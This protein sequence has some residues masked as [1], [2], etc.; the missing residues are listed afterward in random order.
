MKKLINYLVDNQ[1]RVLGFAIV[2]ALLISM[3]TSFIVLDESLTV[4]ITIPVILHAMLQ[5]LCIVIALIL[6]V[7]LLGYA[8]GLIFY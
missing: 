4:V 5:S 2:F 1:R 6:V 7:S 3:F 8:A